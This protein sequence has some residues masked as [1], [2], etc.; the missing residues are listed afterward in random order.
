MQDSAIVTALVLGDGGFLLQHGDLCERQTM[1]EAVGGGETDD[2]AADYSDTMGHLA[3]LNGAAR[4]SRELKS[5]SI[6]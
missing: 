3:I 5:L 6:I 1:E 4:T 2:A